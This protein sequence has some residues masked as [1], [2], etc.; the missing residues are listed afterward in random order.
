VIADSIIRRDGPPHFPETLL[1]TFGDFVS[2]ETTRC[3]VEPIG[4]INERWEARSRRIG[5]T[6][7]SRFSQVIFNSL[8]TH[9]YRGAI[10]V[11]KRRGGTMH[12]QPA[13]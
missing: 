13:W 8:R 7:K 3:M 5:A 11:L 10:H 2:W 12:G 9:G 4:D 1:S 6:D